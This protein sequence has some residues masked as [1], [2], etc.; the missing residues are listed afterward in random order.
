MNNRPPGRRAADGAIAPLYK[1]PAKP[2]APR[3]RRP[4]PLGGALARRWP[5]LLVF[6]TRSSCPRLASRE[7]RRSGRV[8]PH[9]RPPRPPVQGMRGIEWPPRGWPP[10]TPP[11]REPSEIRCPR[12]WPVLTWGAVLP[13]LFLRALVGADRPRPPRAPCSA[14]AGGA[15]FRRGG[16]PPPAARGPGTAFPPRAGKRRKNG[17]RAVRLL[18]MQH[19]HKAPLPHSSQGKMHQSEN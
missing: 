6:V 10:R 4:R 1:P 3:R 2:D 11:R 13:L 15:S 14:R 18:R 9:G 7:P 12:T 16:A 5:V 17:L 19:R 8:A